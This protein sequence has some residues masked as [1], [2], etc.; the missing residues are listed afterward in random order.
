[1]VGR[2]FADLDDMLLKEWDPGLAPVTSVTVVVTNHDHPDAVMAS[3][4][5]IQKQRTKPLRGGP[6]ATPATLP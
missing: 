2:R 5:Q 6:K 1:M 3:G 4:Q